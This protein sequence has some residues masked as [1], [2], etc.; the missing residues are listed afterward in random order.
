[1]TE[2]IIGLREKHD[3]TMKV[4]RYITDESGIP[5]KDKAYKSDPGNQII[6]LQLLI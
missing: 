2:K 4:Q 3:L 5:E 1:M 6:T